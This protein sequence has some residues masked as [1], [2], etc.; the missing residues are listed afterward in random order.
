M[1]KR[2]PQKQKRLA[3]KSSCLTDDPDDD[4]TRR[5]QHE[6]EISIAITLVSTH[7]I[8]LH[9]MEF[10]D[11]RSLVRFGVTCRGTHH[12]LPL[13]LSHRSQRLKE[14]ERQI[15]VLL[16]GAMTDGDNLE[17]DA[18]ACFPSS[19]DIERVWNLGTTVE[20]MIS[21]CIICEDCPRN[22]GLP[23]FRAERRLFRRLYH[24]LHY[25]VPIFKGFGLP[26]ICKDTIVSERQVAA[27]KETSVKLVQAMHFNY[28][29]GSDF[30][31]EAW[32]AGAAIERYNAYWN[33][34]Q[35]DE[36]G[37]L[38]HVFRHAA[39]EL[40]TP[41]KLPAFRIAAWR[42]AQQYPGLD[43]AFGVV[44]EMTKSVWDYNR[45][46]EAAAEADGDNQSQEDEGESSDTEVLEM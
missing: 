6:E 1:P 31:C 39:A 37:G 25:S 12:S 29:N 44:M 17:E 3:L 19:Q 2:R 26:T 21:G 33:L 9:I 7:D 45:N 35:E 41:E 14:M 5:R 16:N 27:A 13:E 18:P 36:S 10:L 46:Q 23:L 24:Q 40:V 8:N 28:V 32:N 20:H 34:I 43:C 38:P 22:E 42:E 4:R 11:V 15:D 30:R